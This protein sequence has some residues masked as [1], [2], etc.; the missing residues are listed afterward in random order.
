MVA[1]GLVSPIPAQPTRQ[2]LSPTVSPAGDSPP[3][4]SSLTETPLRR[5]AEGQLA[6]P[7]APRECIR[8]KACLPLRRR[9][10]PSPYKTVRRRLFGSS[11]SLQ[12]AAEE[13]RHRSPAV[14]ATT[15][16]LSADSSRSPLV[17]GRPLKGHVDL[18][19]DRPADLPS[20]FLAADALYAPTN[21]VYHNQAPVPSGQQGSMRHHA[22]TSLTRHVKHARQRSPAHKD[23]PEIA[24]QR[25][26][27][28]SEIARQRS[29][30][31]SEI[32]RQRSPARQHSPARQC[33]TARHQPTV[34][35]HHAR[36]RSPMRQCSLARPRSA[37][38]QRSP[39]RPRSA[40][41]QRSPARPRSSDLGVVGKSKTSPTR[42]R[43]PMRRLLSPAC[44]RARSPTRAYED[45]CACP[46]R[47][48]PSPTGAT[49]RQ[50]NVRPQEAR[51]RTQVPTARVPTNT[52]SDCARAN[53]H[54][55]RLRARPTTSSGERD[56]S[57]A[58]PRALH[59]DPER[60]RARTHNQPLAHS[61]GSPAHS[62]GSPAHASTRHRAPAHA[63]AIASR[64]RTRISSPPAHAHHQSPARD[65]GYSP[66]RVRQRATPRNRQYPPA[67]E[68][69]E[70][71]HSPIAPVR[72][73]PPRVGKSSRV[74]AEKSLPPSLLES[75]ILPR[76][77]SKDSKTVP[78]S[79]TRLRTEPASH[80]ENVRDS[81][82]EEPLGTG[83]FAERN[84]V[85]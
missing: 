20:P 22:H 54:R 43:S 72:E 32:A 6:D 29:P 23:G 68:S 44:S 37:T 10:L 60:P 49:H 7:M 80:S 33:A 58:R 45:S 17:E 18:P 70:V 85:T 15:L 56:L 73:T 28:V 4:G 12:S 84:T 74:G 40:T 38:C 71:R 34:R 82:Q 63:L 42:Q 2:K 59:T 8:R 16:D 11:L 13:P 30:A 53:E 41:C 9:G 24:R 14:P 77:E 66:S 1:E 21:P 25:S 46:A 67:R 81:P 65:A 55:F 64:S 69:R 83:D 51:Q 35:Q 5:T 62:P 75:C 76:R 52:G 36:Q 3:L 39:A 26:P 79:S 50:P 27:A 48:R 31:V 47:P 19:P 78:K 61:P 57:P